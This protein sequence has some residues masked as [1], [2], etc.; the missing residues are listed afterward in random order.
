M[1]ERAPEEAD[2]AG[3]RYAKFGE[4]PPRIR[5]DEFVETVETQAPPGRP[6]SAASEAQDQ[7]LLGGG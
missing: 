3:L 1:T 5:P 7:A 6:E 2:F 4:L